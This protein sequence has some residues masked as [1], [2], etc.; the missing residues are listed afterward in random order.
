MRSKADAKK[1]IESNYNAGVNA[2]E[3]D[4]VKYATVYNIYQKLREK[5]TLIR[6]SESGRKS[7]IV[8]ET[9]KAILSLWKMMTLI[10]LLK[11]QSW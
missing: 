2:I 10:I 11:Y 9:K 3:I 1:I 8:D 6:K 4:E 7:I 5:G